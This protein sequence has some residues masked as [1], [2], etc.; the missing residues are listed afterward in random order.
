MEK[1][2]KTYWFV[3]PLDAWTNSVIYSEMSMSSGL[4]NTNYTFLVDRNGWIEEANVWEAPHSFISKLYRS[5][6][7]MMLNFRVYNRI[8]SHGPAR[9]WKFEESGYRKTAKRKKIS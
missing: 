2:R 1:K 7:E 5:K 8:G 3:E 4:E 9:L 6:K